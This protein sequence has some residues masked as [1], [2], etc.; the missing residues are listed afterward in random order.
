MRLTAFL[1]PKGF[2]SHESNYTPG[3]GHFAAPFHS[4]CHHGRTTKTTDGREAATQTRGCVN[5][6]AYV[7]DAR[8]G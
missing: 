3:S 7:R 1:K 4:H 8:A 6:G 5:A 2:D